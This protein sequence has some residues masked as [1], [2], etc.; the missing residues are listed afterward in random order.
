MWDCQKNKFFLELDSNHSCKLNLYSSTQETCTSCTVLITIALC[1]P[2]IMHL[3]H[4]CTH[5]SPGECFVLWALY[6]YIHHWRLKREHNAKGFWPRN[7]NNTPIWLT[8]LTCPGSI[9]YMPCSLCTV[10]IDR[11]TCGSELQQPECWQYSS[12]SQCGSQERI[13]I[14][15]IIAV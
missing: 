15:P 9:H 14:L 6:S 5:V 10:S 2:S 8:S 11:K 13:K 1:H 7:G 4:P 12:L 3:S